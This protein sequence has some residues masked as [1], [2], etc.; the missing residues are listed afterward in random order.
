MR[1]PVRDA[2][3]ARRRNRRRREAAPRAGWVRPL[4]RAQCALDTTTRLVDRTLSEI[5]SS[6]QCAHLRPVR[7]TKDLHNASARLVAASQKLQT[8]AR[9]LAEVNEWILREPERSRHAP[10]LLVCATECW[11]DTAELLQDAADQLVSLQQAVL[12]G[13]ES[14]ELV[15]EPESAPRRPRIIILM[16]RPMPIRAFLAVRQPR[17][18]N[19]IGPILRRRRR[20]LRPA[21]IRVPRRTLLGRAPPVSS[22]CA[23]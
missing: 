4:F 19:R 21:A 9:K 6:E 14:G 12:E 2:V 8:A 22:T 18:A 20:I 17:V 7:T 15:P 10:P 5:A 11:V 16:P 1:A 13:L 3:G 23:L